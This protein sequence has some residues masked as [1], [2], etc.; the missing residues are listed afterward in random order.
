MSTLSILEQLCFSTTRIETEDIDGN[1]YSGTGFFFSFALDE[2]KI[3]PLLITNKHMVI[4]MRTGMFK[5]TK[6]DEQGNPIYTEHVTIKLDNFEE[7]WI[8]HPD[9]DVDLCVMLLG[10]LLNIQKQNGQ[11]LFFRTFDN[12]LIPTTNELKSLNIIEDIIMIGYPNGLW[13]FVNNMPIIRKGI[14]A[15]AAYLDYN[16][17]KEFLIDAACFHGSSGSPVLLCDKGGY[18]DKKGNYTFGSSR[19][20]LLGILYGGPQSTITGE[21]RV[22]TIPNLQQHLQQQAVPIFQ[23][24][25]NLGCI[26]KSE[27]ILDF[28]P[29]IK[30][31]LGL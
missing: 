20:M 18:Y 10:Q 23:I 7:N 30:S 3:V 8:L 5:F 13:D 9:D 31:K 11:N 15:T 25:N 17:K 14:T 27:R 6:A 26:I 24:P 22:V 16:G 19:I 1:Q 4:N 21:I 2:K 29:I 28:I 12:K